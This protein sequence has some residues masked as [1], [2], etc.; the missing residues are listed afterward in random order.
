MNFQPLYRVT[1]KSEIL[2]PRNPKPRTLNPS[3]GFSTRDGVASE[4]PFATPSVRRRFLQ[5]APAAA[6]RHADVVI[7]TLFIVVI[8]NSNSNRNFN[9]NSKNNSYSNRT[10]NSS[11]NSHSNSTGSGGNK[12]NK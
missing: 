8:A 5:T 3:L 2:S 10:S 9:S 4:A 12:S 1:P 7:R 11:S 6:Q